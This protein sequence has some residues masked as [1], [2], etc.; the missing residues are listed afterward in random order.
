MSAPARSAGATSRREYNRIRLSQEDEVVARA[1]MRSIDRQMTP[2]GDAHGDTRASLRSAESLTPRATGALLVVAVAAV[3]TAAILVRVASAPA[4][5]LAFWRTAV[6]SAVLVPF[7]VRASF[8]PDARGW[9][10]LVGAGLA[11]ALHFALFIGSLSFTTVASSVVLVSSSPMFVGVIAV[12]R[13]TEAPTPR[14]WAGIALGMLGAAV[15]ALGDRSSGS[16]SAPLLGNLMALG[17]AVTFALYLVTGRALRRRLPVA[18]YAA[19]VYGIAAVALAVAC[20]ASST[21]VGIRSSWPASTWWAIAG[22]VAG[23]QLLGHTVF[24]TVLARV[25]AAVVALVVL[26]EP[27]GSALLAAVLLS[28]VPTLPFYLGAPLILIGVWFGTTRGRQSHT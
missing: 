12:L 1:R 13:R 8:R 28:E 16:A 2:S 3:S 17:G 10:A 7:A 15:V 5:A 18:V 20:L 21:S 23:P 25:S 26:A 24:N 9:P 19:W 6:G 11:L 4:L 22:L 14:G 27:L